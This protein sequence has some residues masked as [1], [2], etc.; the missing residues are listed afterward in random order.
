[1]NRAVELLKCSADT[2]RGQSMISWSE[3]DMASVQARR[4]KAASIL[5]IPGLFGGFGLCLNYAQTTHKDPHGTTRNRIGDA[6]G[7]RRKI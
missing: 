4:C 5:A 2:G 3:L 6:L 1:M 7:T